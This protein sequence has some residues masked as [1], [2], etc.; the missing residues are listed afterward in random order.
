VPPIRLSDLTP[1]YYWDA[2]TGRYQDVNTG[3]FVSSAQVRTSLDR[4]IESSQTRLEALTIQLQG[5]RLTLAEW[6]TQFALTIK[7]LACASGALAKGG[8]AQMT[9]ADWGKVGWEVRRQYE[10]L[11]NFALDIGTGKQAMDGRMLVRARMY[12]QAV[13]GIYE[14][15]R[16]ADAVDAGKTQERRILGVAEHCLDCVDYARRDWQ[17]IGTLPRIGNSQCLTNCHCTFEY[18]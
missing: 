1:A 17:P 9:P 7:R 18:R 15:V 10:F 12:G 5:G 11:H 6:E 13:R 8:W 2:R 14:E 3:R 16:R 4:F